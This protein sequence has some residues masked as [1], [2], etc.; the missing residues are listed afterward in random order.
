MHIHISDLATSDKY[1]HLTSV[2]GLTI[3][4]RYATTDNFMHRDLYAPHD[5]AWLHVDACAALERVIAWLNAN[6]KMAS[7]VVLDAVRP[8]RVQQQLWD[9]VKGTELSQYVAD[10]SY[11]SIHE[12]GMA[13]DVSLLDD[14]GVELDM[15][16]FFDDM[17][18]RSHP[19][20]E[21]QMLEAGELTLTQVANRQLLRDAMRA[22]GFAGISTEW[23]HFDLG[24][25]KTVR[26]TYP[27]IV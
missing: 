9:A 20:K 24:D 17:T 22:G 3:D 19:A 18:D 25:R 4:L 23:W 7:L 6:A 16:T 15:G 1:R 5:C 27:R 11:G 21:Q 26:A 2:D 12:F 13:V 10:P 14:A 8:R